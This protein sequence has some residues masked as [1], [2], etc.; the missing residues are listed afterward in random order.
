FNLL[1]RERPYFLTVNYDCSCQFVFLEHRNTK[2]GSCASLIDGN[3]TQGLTFGV[4]TIGLEI[5]NVYNLLSSGKLAQGSPLIWSYRPMLVPERTIRWRNIVQ[6]HRVKTLTVVKQNVT[7]FGVTD[8]QSLSK[9]GL[10]NRFHVSR[11]R[12]NDL[13]YVG[14]RSLQLDG[15][16]A[17]S[18]EAIHKLL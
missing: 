1:T 5:R 3:D 18:P 7:E 14:A 4:S 16:V 2:E 15:F 6:M 8:A 10:E 17:F 11:D 12:T 9:H 13:Q